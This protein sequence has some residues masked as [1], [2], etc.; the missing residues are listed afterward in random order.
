MFPAIMNMLH[1]EK[2]K[3]QEIKS[4]NINTEKWAYRSSQYLY[5]ITLVTGGFWIVSQILNLIS[6]HKTGKCKH[7][8]VH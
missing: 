4:H 8:K 2:H 6:L 5:P 3:M 1:L 7:A